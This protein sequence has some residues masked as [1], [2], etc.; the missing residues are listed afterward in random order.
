MNRRHAA[1]LFQSPENN[2]KKFPIVGKISAG[3][4][5]HWKNYS[6]LLMTVPRI[7]F[8]P[9]AQASKP[10]ENAVYGT[11]RDSTISGKAGDPISA[12]SGAFSWRKT[13]F[14]PGGPMD[15]HST[16]TC[17]TDPA[18]RP[19]HSPG[20]FPPDYDDWDVAAVW[21]WSPAGRPTT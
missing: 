8:V 9:D 15:L 7:F 12:A 5:N 4:S 16:L 11:Q 18:L 19:P 10:P 17:R 20:D 2:E 6:M 13:L 14:S 21:S 3:F 1:V